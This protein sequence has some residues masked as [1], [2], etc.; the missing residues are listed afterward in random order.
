[1]SGLAVNRAE[2]YTP[3]Y[4]KD[5][6][7]AARAAKAQKVAEKKTAPKRAPKAPEKDK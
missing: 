2:L 4:I 6:G 5:R 3:Q 7:K 1:M